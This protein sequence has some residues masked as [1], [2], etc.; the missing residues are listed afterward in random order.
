MPL[1]FSFNI[2]IFQGRS[3]ET[4]ENIT[5]Y[6][7]FRNPFSGFGKLFCRVTLSGILKRIKA[8]KFIARL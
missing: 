7:L 5:K 8:D 4:T 6:L 2:F 1:F 3:A